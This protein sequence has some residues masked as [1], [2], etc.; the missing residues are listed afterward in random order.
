MKLEAL[1]NTHRPYK[2]TKRI[3]RGI[4]SGMGKTSCRG[5]KGAGSRSGWKSRARYEGGQLP[6]Y[7]KIPGRGFSNARFQKK[8]DAINLG[9][10]ETL[11]ADGETVNI[12]TLR[13]VG[14]LC[15]TSYGIKILSEGTLTKKV[16][17]EAHSFSK[18]AEEKLS[19][20]NI[21]YSQTSKTNK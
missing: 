15:G 12:D 8:L 20:A 3:G 14:F 2:R 7:R 9:Q 16:T 21:A 5:H 10:I 18:K 4:G 11:F 19:Q 17:I 1:Q 13:K 6:L